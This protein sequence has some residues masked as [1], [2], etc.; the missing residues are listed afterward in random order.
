MTQQHVEQSG[1][2]IQLP[3]SALHIEDEI[4][5]PPRSLHVCCG[6]GSGITQQHIVPEH[7]EE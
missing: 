7:P 5:P 1:E 2:D 6:S 3:P 4:H